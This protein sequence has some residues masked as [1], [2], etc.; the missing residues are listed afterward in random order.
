LVTTLG[1]EELIGVSGLGRKEEGRSVAAAP[2]LDRSSPQSRRSAPSMVRSH[3]SSA[4]RPPYSSSKGV[5]AVTVQSKTKRAAP[6]STADKGPERRTAG[7]GALAQEIPPGN[8]DD[9]VARRLRH[10]AEDERDPTLKKKL[11]SEYLQY[12]ANIVDKPS[13]APDL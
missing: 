9:V 12:H 10:A 4:S 3:L 8:D 1:I 5:H 11:W 2:E 7:N 6:I 13:A